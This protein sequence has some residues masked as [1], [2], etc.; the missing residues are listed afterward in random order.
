MGLHLP[1][2]MYVC[3]HRG[4]CSIAHLLSI[5]RADVSANAKVLS[6]KLKPS[7]KAATDSYFSLC[8]FLIGNFGSKNVMWKHFLC[9]LCQGSYFGLDILHPH[10]D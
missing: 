7:E 5:S 8:S 2:D 9:C 6:K 4:C 10:S 3:V 1:A